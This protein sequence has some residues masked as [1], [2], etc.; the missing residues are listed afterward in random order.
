MRGMIGEEGKR[1]K[2]EGVRGKGQ[3]EG[4]E[5]K[6]FHLSFDIFHFPLPGDLLVMN[7]NS[8]QINFLSPVFA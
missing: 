6:I 8:T 2:G 4:E 5:K 1:G 7:H 3:G